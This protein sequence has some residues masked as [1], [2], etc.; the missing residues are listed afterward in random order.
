M[1]SCYVPAMIDAYTWT[2]PNG[3]KLLIALEELGLPYRTHWVD[4]TKGE[5][6]KPAFLA[7]N[8]N[9]KIPALVDDEGPGGA[10]ISIFESGAILSYL[11]DKTGQLWPSGAARYVVQEWMYFQAGGTGPMGGQLG[12]WNHFA[13][14]KYA[15]AI[16]RYRTEVLR[17]LGVLDKRLGEVPFLAGEYSM[18]DIMNVTWPRANEKYGAIDLAPFANVSRWLGEVE[19]RPAVAKALAMKP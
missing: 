3:W 10:P 6:M 11:G 16:E 4:I 1:P 5:Q 14:E 15:P 9:N 19:A 12:Y 2:T 13:K 7:I 17:L 18:A 8:P